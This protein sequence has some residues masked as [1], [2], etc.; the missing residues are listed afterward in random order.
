MLA[1]MVTTEDNP[2][3][4]FT[5]YDNWLRFDE[6]Q[7]Y[8]T[9]NYLMRVARVSNDSS[10]EEYQSVINDAAYEIAEMNLT[11]NYKL[12]VGELET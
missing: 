6:E 8:Y 5:D 10:D 1:Y 9:L 2:Y 11:G 12:V 7:G 3:D 4:Y